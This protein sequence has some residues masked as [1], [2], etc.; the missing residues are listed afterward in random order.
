MRAGVDLPLA[1]ERLSNMFPTL[2]Q[3][4]RESGWS[5]SHFPAIFIFGVLIYHYFIPSIGCVAV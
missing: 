3:M 5:A 2:P 1:M 4:E